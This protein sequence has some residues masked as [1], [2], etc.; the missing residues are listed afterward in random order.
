MIACVGKFTL[1]VFLER[2]S[3][4]VRG[5]FPFGFEGEMRELIV[6][7]PDHCPSLYFMVLK[8]YVRH[9]L[10]LQNVPNSV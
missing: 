9:F 2:L 7:V 6:L 3:V 10:L 8:V 1:R 5:S 4:C